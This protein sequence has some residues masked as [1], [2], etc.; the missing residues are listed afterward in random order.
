MRRL[1]LKTPLAV[2]FNK[3]LGKGVP[4]YDSEQRGVASADF[5]GSFSQIFKMK[6]AILLLIWL[7]AFLLKTNP[8][9]SQPKPLNESNRAQPQNSS[10]PIFN[11]TKPDLPDQDFASITARPVFKG[12]TAATLLTD[13]PKVA[14]TDS[15]RRNT[16]GL[17]VGLLHYRT[18]DQQMSPLTYY[19]T[20][21]KAELFWRRQKRKNLIDL[22]F[23]AGFGKGHQ[24]GIDQRIYSL[25]SYEDIHGTVKAEELDYVPAFMTGGL[26]FS[27]LRKMPVSMLRSGD[28]YIGAQVNETLVWPGILF[29]G[30]NNMLRLDAKIEQQKVLSPKVK[31]RVAGTIPLVGM[32]TRPNYS[33]VATTPEKESLFGNYFKEGTSLTSW[34]THQAIDLSAVVSFKLFKRWYISGGYDFGWYRISNPKP[35]IAYTNQ[36]NFIS[37]FKF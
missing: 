5:C 23:F 26:K 20:V 8:V 9:F 36:L 22:S 17:S 11:G 30:I 7:I 4:N 28:L 32:I 16:L 31:L 34:N 15:L 3:F 19:F 24:K 13:G 10:P 29:S 27:W 14:R 37:T 18:V 1:I 21:P 25:T 12:A 6:K 35:V 33:G 2:H